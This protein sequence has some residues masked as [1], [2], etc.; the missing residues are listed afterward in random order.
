[1][2]RKLRVFLSSTMRDLMN[3]RA[4]V[5]ARLLQFNFEPVNAEQWQPTGK[6]SWERIR[7]EIASSDVF[8]LL[9][10]ERYGWTP[11]AGP[12][13][14]SGKSVT[15]MEYLEACDQALPILPFLKRLPYDAE[16]DSD[17]ARRRDAFRKEVADWN[18]GQLVG[19]F[20]L[21]RD[22]S[23]N[24][25][26]ALVDMLCEDFKSRL[27]TRA[28][29]TEA[30]AS[31][32]ADA[33]AVEEPQLP[34]RIV[35]EVRRHEA[36]LFAGAGVSLEAGYPAAAAWGEF[37]MQRIRERVPDYD[38]PATAGNVRRIAG[39]LEFVA[40][41]DALLAAVKALLTPAHTV[42]VTE[43]HHA[44]VRHFQTI[45]TSNFDNLFE[46]ASREGGH[47]HGVVHGELLAPTPLRSLIVKFYGS[48]EYPDTMVLTEEQAN[49]V[50]PAREALLKMIRHTFAHQPVV[51]VGSSLRDPSTAGLFARAVGDMH[52]YYVDRRMGPAA[53][54]NAR[55][56]NLEPIRATAAGFFRA[57]DRAL[58]AEGADAA[59][60][61]I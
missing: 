39:D 5:T 46:L 25:G 47:D 21:A 14:A 12:G 31:I 8:L 36:V 45:I 34:G 40:G 59:A 23:D 16:R 49:A 18:G 41:R 19:Q 33:P 10:G 4:E 3:E 9:L 53:V 35:E 28:A 56:W 22:L 2:G 54:L 11:D 13:A 29:D 44:A 48:F 26:R 61:A 60:P 37:L 57:L 30:A 6:Q 43:V 58:S 42:E 52:G 38:M 32:I 51:V 20:D 50:T 15:H 27:R 24:V 1:M 55:R 7:Q 17:D